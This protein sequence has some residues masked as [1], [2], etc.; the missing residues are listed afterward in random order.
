MIADKVQLPT[1]ENKIR[2]ELVDNYL[3]KLVDDY[4]FKKEVQNNLGRVDIYVIEKLTEE[5]PHFIVECKLLDNKNP[6]GVE[7]LN[8]KYVTNGIQRFLTEHY[9]IDN[10]YNTNAMV[11]FITK[12]VNITDNINNINTLVSKKFKKFNRSHPKD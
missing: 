10:N 8:A 2:D 9:F 1:N 3:I 12:T 6:D 4:E 5:K 11:G 7:G